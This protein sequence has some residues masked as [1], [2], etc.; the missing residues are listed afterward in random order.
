MEQ[1]RD[2]ASGLGSPGTLEIKRLDW[3]WIWG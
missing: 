3:G 1:V 2:D